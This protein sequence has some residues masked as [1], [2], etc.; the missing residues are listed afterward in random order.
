MGRQC[1]LRHEHGTM[2]T[3]RQTDRQ[4]GQTYRQA[5]R[6][7]GQGNDGENVVNTQAPP[8]LRGNSDLVDTEHEPFRRSECGPRQIQFH[9]DICM[10]LRRH[11]S[12][13]FIGGSKAHANM[14]MKTRVTAVPD[15]EQ[16]VP[17]REQKVPDPDQ[18]KTTHTHTHVMEHFCVSTVSVAVVRIK[19][20]VGD[21]G[22]VREFLTSRSKRE[23]Y[24]FTRI[25][26]YLPASLMVG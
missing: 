13:L 6:E 10:E 11:H 7:C 2:L 17:E 12:S 4:T 8:W 16:K 22:D 19:S 5:D 20:D 1:L 26:R 24:R 9:L 15:P 14:H 23:K 18:R 25:Y 21:D 3:D